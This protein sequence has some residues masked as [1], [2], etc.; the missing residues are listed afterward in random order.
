MLSAAGLAVFL[1]G[2]AQTYGVSPFVEPMLTEL[3]W[4]RS[5]FSAAYSVG[6]LAS[7]G[8]LLLIGRQ[9]D[10]WGNRLVFSLAA[11]VFAL[12][13][14]LMSAVGG[15]VT[16]LLGF[17][18][19]RTFGSGVLTLAA[20][21][22]I[23]HWFIRRRGRAFSLLG[24]ASTLSLAL[25]PPLNE[26]LIDAFGW[27]GAWRA[28]AVVIVLVLLPVVAFVVR[29][30]P[31]LVGQ[32]P[33]GAPPRGDGHDERVEEG[34]F[35]L[36][37]ALRTPAFWG[38]LGASAVPS[39]VVTGLAFNQVAIFTDRGLPGTLAAIT[40][41]VESAVG[42]PTTLLAGWLVD[43]YPL[44]YTLAAGQI[45]L[46]IALVALLA[47]NSPALALFY[48]AWRG[49]SSGLWM[50]A[51]DVAWPAYFGRRH[52]GSIRS[53]GFAV[54]VVG[55]ALGPLPLGLAY[56]YLGGYDPAIAGMLVLP[57]IAAIAVLRATPPAAQPRVER[58]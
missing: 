5:L 19:L 15:L 27:R 33:D 58:G 2:P 46:L 56:D 34:S 16:L 38:L 37:E 25:F 29:D 32:H 49:A 4:S 28:N 6:T 17:A 42:L 22:L 50:V 20:R 44:R 43:R 8:A 14:L 40:F 18:L 52:L 30:R 26:V 48:S 39:F 1:S 11:V 53:V 12:A 24:L 7:A 54:G 36:R 55:A 3:G 23:P 31:E 45:C 10:R 21:T 47:A 9:I 51:A 35:A 13:L 57:V 41:S